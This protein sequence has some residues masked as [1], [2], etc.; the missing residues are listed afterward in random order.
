MGVRHRSLPIEGVQ[1]HPESI[2]T[3]DGHD[4][5]R[6]FLR[7][8]R[9]RLI[10]RRRRP[11]RDAV[12]PPSVRGGGRVVVV[13]VVVGAVVV[14]PWWSVAWSSWS[15]SL[16]VVGGTA[17]P[18]VRR[19]WS[20]GWTCCPRRALRP[21]PAVVGRAERDV[22]VADRD[23]QATAAERVAGLGLG[24]AV[25]VRDADRL[26]T[27]GDEQGDRRALGHGVLAAGRCG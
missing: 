8:H 1:F 24:L 5:L 15:S 25:D 11:C 26:R 10:G 12:A 20:P 19:R 14:V 6:N 2:L 9:R 21:H 4:L 17:L 23:L 16:V 22:H 13:V 27:A 18:T 3:G 7:R